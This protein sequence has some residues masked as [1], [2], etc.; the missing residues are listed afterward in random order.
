MASVMHT[1]AGVTR[2]LR[3][4]LVPVVL[5]ALTS[6]AQGRLRVQSR[7]PRSATAAARIAAAFRKAGVK[8]GTLNIHVRRG[9][10]LWSTTIRYVAP[11]RPPMVHV[12]RARHGRIN[13][14][15]AAAAARRALASLKGRRRAPRRRPPPGDDIKVEAEEVPKA[16]APDRGA[17]REERA[18]EP[19]P[20]PAPAPPPA[21]ASKPPAAATDDSLGFEVDDAPPRPKKPAPPPE[22]KPEKKEQVATSTP[23]SDDGVAEYKP[24]AP[25]RPRRRAGVAKVPRGR[26]VAYLGAG[27]GLA[28]RRFLLDAV[29]SA[30]NFESGVF[31]QISIHGDVFPLQLVTRSFFARLGLRLAYA[32]SAGLTTETDQGESLS[33]ENSRL[34]A[35]LTYL[36]PR[37]RNPRLP[38]FDL[39]VGVAH[40]GYDVDDNTQVQDF[41]VTAFAAGATVTVMFKRYMGIE[42]GGEYRTL[43]RVRSDFMAPFETGPGALQGFHAAGGVR[44]RVIGGLGYRAAVSAER[45]VGDLPALQGENVL[46]VRDW[47]VSADVALTFQM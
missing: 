9:T 15:Q 11:G 31:S 37:F 4:V 22:K 10:P 36:V 39:R 14:A 21:P 28:W 7:G 26:V 35:G 42:L 20:A 32:H 45:F 5:G 12:I 33:T 46:Q 44:G 30:V 41:S 3:L 1:T 24:E 25:A 40:T 8:V 38:R 6:P 18:R 13:G 19:A 29:S 16:A 2:L 27:L 47:T 34:W 23:G 17:Q 43:L